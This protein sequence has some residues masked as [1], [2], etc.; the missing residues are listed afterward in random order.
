MKCKKKC[1][2]VKPII[3]TLDIAK[4][5]YNNGGEYRFVVCVNTNIPHTLCKTYKEARDVCLLNPNTFTIV[6]LMELIF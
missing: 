2:A 3:I 6:D 4:E 5:M 1:K